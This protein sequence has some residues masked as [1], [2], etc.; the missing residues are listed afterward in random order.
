M[1]TATARAPRKK[2][3]PPDYEVELLM[4]FRAFGLPEPKRQFYFAK[5]LKRRWRSDFGWDEPLYMLI[6]EVEGATW[7]GGRHTRGA[8]FEAD[9]IKYGEAILLGY[10]VIRVTGGMVR[11]GRALDLVR[12]ALAARGKGEA[13]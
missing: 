1:T 13:A 7:A 9:C 11:D 3:P 2:A 5:A 4:Q 12:R 8:G 6:V 10:R